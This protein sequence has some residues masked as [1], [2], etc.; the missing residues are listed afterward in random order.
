MFI[1]GRPT[2]NNKFTLSS[3]EP[4]QETVPE[5]HLCCGISHAHRL[6]DESVV[7]FSLPAKQQFEVIPINVLME[8]WCLALSERLLKQYFQSCIINC[9]SSYLDSNT[10]K[11]LRESLVTRGTG[12]S[13]R[14]IIK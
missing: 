6:T 5:S 3:F 13:A 10:L 8:T 2:S 9:T 4:D 12:E 11:R 14:E 7:F 1:W